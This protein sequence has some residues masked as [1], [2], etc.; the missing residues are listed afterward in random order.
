MHWGIRHIATRFALLLGLAAI[1]PLLAYGVLSIRSLQQGTRTSV[2]EGNGNV[3]TR[4]AEEVGRYVR[5]YADLLKALGADLQN[6]G[7]QRWQQDRIIKNFVLQFPEFREI[8]LFDVDGDVL[9]TSRIG[10]PRVTL[11]P[12]APM[13][14]DGVGMS[15]TFSDD[16]LLP[17]AVFSAEM[18][19][20][21]APAGWLAGEFSLEQLWRMVDRIRIG[22]E[23][24]AMVLAPGGELLAHGAP[25][26]KALIA[27][28]R[29]MSAHPLV[30]AILSEAEPKSPIAAEYTDESGVRRLGVGT[31][32]SPLGWI[33]VVEQPTAEAYATQTALQRELMVAIIVALLLMIGVG[34]GLGRGFIRPILVLQKGTHAV[35]AGQLDARVDIRTG[36]EFSDLGDAF[37][38]MAARLS[39]LKEDVKRQERQ[40]TLGRLAAGLVHDLSHPVQ[41]IG[42][43]LRLLFREEQDQETSDTLRRTIDRE[44]G[45]LKRFIEDLRNLA[46]PRPIERFAVDVNGSLADV[47]EPARADA[48]RA[49]VEIEARYADCPLTIDGDRFAIGRVFR[50]LL[51][52]ALQASEPGGRVAVNTKR[53]GD[54][55]VITVSDTGIGIP[56]DRLA[57]IFDEFMTTKRGGLG[58]GLAISKR[59]VEQLDG[60][61]DVESDSRGTVF[62]VTFPSRENAAAES[63]AS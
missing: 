30:S 32:I 6:T 4:A 29:N 2:V 41:N 60:T 14:I 52:N 15:P 19:Q 25:D 39:E 18:R 22:R 43:S 53:V 42:N 45:T 56:S 16:A 23:G 63:A 1:A 20:L 54:R 40:A 49:G 59:I 13:T 12:N 37:N 48:Q 11:P 36:D 51:T 5:T 44:L 27:Q 58:L 10:R 46:N 38:T 9:A 35:A 8:T 17:T 31:R 50:N 57:S 62:T 34:Y 61:I 3:A 24:H 33:I 55:I 21:D 26:K 47:V 7:L 28:R